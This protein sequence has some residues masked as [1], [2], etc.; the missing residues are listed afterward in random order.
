MGELQNLK[1]P[2]GMKNKVA[3]VLAGVKCEWARV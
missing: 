2:V 1:Y 3:E